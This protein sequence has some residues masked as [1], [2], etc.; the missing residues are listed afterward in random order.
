MSRCRAETV[1]ECAKAGQVKR[2]CYGGSSMEKRVGQ[3]FLAA[4]I[5]LGTLNVQGMRAQGKASPEEKVKSLIESTSLDSAQAKPW[6]M[7]LAVQLADDNGK[8]L[9]PGTIEEWWKSPSESKRVYSLPGYQG[10]EI[11]TADGLYRTKGMDVPSM[12]VATLVREVIHPVTFYEDAPGAKPVAHPLTMGKAELQCVML[13]RPSNQVAYPPV[14]LFRTYCTEK[15]KD[16]LLL[17]MENGYQVVSRGGNGAFQGKQV[18]TQLAVTIA[19]RTVATGHVE[20][21]SSAGVPA[22]PFAATGDMEQVREKPLVLQSVKYDQYVTQLV[23]PKFSEVS[24]QKRAQ[25]EIEVIVLV[26]RD[27]KVRSEMLGRYPDADI[28]LSALAAVRQWTFKPD[29]VDGQAQPF[30]MTLRMDPAGEIRENG[31]RH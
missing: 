17:T 29:M 21:L 30:L 10:T 26:G 13:Q 31:I 20:T 2:K 6:H 28:A 15:G 19:G 23:D 16:A 5:V 8:T 27:G 24:R 4:M 12:A 11:R 3:S 1:L 14:G 25:G 22:E 7:K 9:G 18:A